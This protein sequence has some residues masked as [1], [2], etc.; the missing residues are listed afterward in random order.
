[1]SRRYKRIPPSKKSSFVESEGGFYYDMLVEWRFTLA[2]GD[3][4]AHGSWTTE[5][6][7]LEATHIQE[8][9]TSIV[10]FDEG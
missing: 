10:I 3:H 4:L 2:V 1:M 5:S 6:I 8:I 9:L 7:P